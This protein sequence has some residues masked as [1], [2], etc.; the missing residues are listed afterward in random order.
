MLKSYFKIAWR[1]LIRNKFSTFV[2]IGGLAIGMAVATL[3]GLWIHDEFSYNKSFTN[4]DRVGRIMIKWAGSH[5]V[6]SSQPLPMGIEIR[7]GFKDDFKHVVLSTQTEDHVFAA[8]DN[9]FRE[10]GKYMQPEVTEML[11]MKML[12][13]SRKG[14]QN[15]NSILLS[16]TL[17]NKLFP[18]K[19]MQ[20]TSRLKLTTESMFW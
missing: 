6:G 20:S 17:A 9:K 14:L 13:G 11:S 7:N 18:K 15:L 2:N 16:N 10:R 8:G 19:E 12:S 1:N 4:Y 3:I 5:R